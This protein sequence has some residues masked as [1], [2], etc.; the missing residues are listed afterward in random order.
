VSERDETK[1]FQ[2]PM[3]LKE[4]IGIRPE[5]IADGGY[6]YPPGDKRRYTTEGWEVWQRQA[7]I[8]DLRR[9]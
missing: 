9:Y 4:F 5:H 6:A 1:D 3:T 7:G 2:W 8:V